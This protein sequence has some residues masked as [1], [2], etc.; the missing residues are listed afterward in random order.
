MPA[1]ERALFGFVGTCV[2]LAWAM[3]EIVHHYEIALG[4]AA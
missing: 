3:H 4:K 1:L 2:V